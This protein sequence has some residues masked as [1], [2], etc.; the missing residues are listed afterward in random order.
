M[1]SDTASVPTLALTATFTAEAIR[2]PLAFWME[3]LGWDYAI[4]FAAYNQVFQELLNPGSLLR[5]NRNGINAILVRLEDWVRFGDSAVP[6]TTEIEKNVNEL[7]DALQSNAPAFASP[8]LVCLCPASPHFLDD[9]GRAEFQG[10]MEERLKQGL[11]DLLGVYLITNA[12]VQAL[13]PVEELHD[14]HADELGHVPY[15]PL[16]SPHSAP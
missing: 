11:Q 10:C 12:E 6:D 2:Q 14:A 1:I 13:Y 7:I 4:A 5:A 9:P 16:F 8:L 3:E 15:T